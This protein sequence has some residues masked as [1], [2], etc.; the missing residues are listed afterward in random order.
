VRNERRLIYDRSMERLRV[1]IRVLSALLV[2]LLARILSDGLTIA[3]GLSEA[4]I[5]LL[6]LAA[7]GLWRHGRRL[8]SDAGSVPE[9]RHR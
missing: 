2:A 5:A 4:L 9:R 3:V 1:T 7:L 8:G 6:L